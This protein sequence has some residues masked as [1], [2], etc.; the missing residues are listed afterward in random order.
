MAAKKRPTAP[1]PPLPTAAAAAEA[2]ILDWEKKKPRFLSLEEFDARA[3]KDILNWGDLPVDL[4]FRVILITE[5]SS[6]NIAGNGAAAATSRYAELEDA[7]G[8]MRKAWLPSIVEKELLKFDEAEIR[9]G[10]IFIRTLGKKTSKTTGHSY[11]G[12][13]IVKMH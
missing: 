7:G 3:S 6:F 10:G 5:V 8:V 13:R 4:V 12:F 9:R 11:H 2:S 1:A